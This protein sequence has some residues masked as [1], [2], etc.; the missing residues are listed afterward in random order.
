MKKILST[1]H[2]EDVALLAYLDAELP[3][4]ATRRTER[5]LQSCWKCRSALA[6]LELQAQTVSRLLSQRDQ[7]DIAR[8]RDAKDK[9]LQRKASLETR[10]KERPKTKS[11]LF[12]QRSAWSWTDLLWEMLCPC[13]Q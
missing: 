3:R 5:H 12:N 8:T 10:W 6:E 2:P 1:E 11:L 9:F 13:R 7:S 4:A